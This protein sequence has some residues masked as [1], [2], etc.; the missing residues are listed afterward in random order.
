MNHIEHGI[1]K[2]IAPAIITIVPTSRRSHR[3]T[4]RRHQR[5]SSAIAEKKYVRTKRK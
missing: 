5:A 1:I 4:S 3:H 2:G